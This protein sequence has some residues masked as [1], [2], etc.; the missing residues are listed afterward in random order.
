MSHLITFAAGMIVGVTLL[1]IWAV[2]G[3]EDN[4]S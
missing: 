3:G 4:N 1:I 2:I